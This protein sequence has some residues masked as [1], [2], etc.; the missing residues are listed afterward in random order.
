M[1]LLITATQITLKSKLSDGL[2]DIKV[3]DENY[4]I[5]V[6][7]YLETVGFKTYVSRRNILHINM[8]ENRKMELDLCGVIIKSILMP[9]TLQST[10]QELQEIK[11]KL[12]TE[13]N[14]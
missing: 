8:N 5:L 1:F 4:F 7:G 10:L 9:N 13:P 6:K 12:D 14:I 3:S 11:Y 2:L